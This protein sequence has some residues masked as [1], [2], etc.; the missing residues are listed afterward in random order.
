MHLA[1]F[2]VAALLLTGAAAGQADIPDQWRYVPAASGR[3]SAAELGET[4]AY[5]FRIQ[6]I[7]ARHELSFEYFP[8]DGGPGDWTEEARNSGIDLILYYPPD[9]ETI[10]EVHGPVTGN[11]LT[12]TLPLTAD[13]SDEIAEAPEIWLYGENG[14]SNVTNGGAAVAVRRVASECAPPRTGS[15]LPRVEQGRET[16]EG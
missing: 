15:R 7:P 2:A 14:P 12:G 3:G 8:G 9:T 13:L 16:S 1:A 6:C 5:G 10:F 4:G 11:S